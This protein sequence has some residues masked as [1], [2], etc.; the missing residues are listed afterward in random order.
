MIAIAALV[1][2]SANA[3]KI[4][5]KQHS[6]KWTQK[7]CKLSTS[8]SVMKELK[9]TALLVK[10]HDASNFNYLISSNKHVFFSLSVAWSTDC[11][12]S[13]LRISQLCP[14]LMNRLPEANLSSYY[15]A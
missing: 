15:V 14:S 6:A 1:M 13:F 12:R 3:V 4:E 10:E 5:T 2:S 11:L 9:R 8:A 7:I